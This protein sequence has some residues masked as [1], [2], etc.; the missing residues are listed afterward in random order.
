MPSPAAARMQRLNSRDYEASLP[1]P[2]LKCRQA[3]EQLPEAALT[4]GQ[5][6]S[7]IETFEQQA[8]ALAPSKSFLDPH[9]VHRYNE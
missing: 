4:R 2:E 3:C 1:P 5:T 7:G 8:R 6:M 9:A